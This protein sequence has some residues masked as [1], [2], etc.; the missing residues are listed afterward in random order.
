[1]TTDIIQGLD[2]HTSGDD[3]TDNENGSSAKKVITTAGS[4]VKS[5]ATSVKDTT[6]STAKKV[7]ENERVAAAGTKVKKAATSDTVKE[8]RS[9]ILGV[10]GALV[11]LVVVRR[12]RKGR[13]A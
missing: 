8:H 9:K 12:V 10:A 1:M 11:L 2:N 3:V 7:A 4:A 6:V 13:K 5:A